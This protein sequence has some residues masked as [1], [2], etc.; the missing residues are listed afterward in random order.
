MAAR[1]EAEAALS[2][3]WTLCGSDKEHFYINGVGFDAWAAAARGTEGGAVEV[4][5]ATSEAASYRALAARLKGDLRH[6]DAWAPPP[7][8]AEII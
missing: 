4:A 2:A 7:G 5:V 8:R 6:T 1:G 3:G